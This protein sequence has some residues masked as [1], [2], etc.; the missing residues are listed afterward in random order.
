M[1]GWPL[2]V[3]VN[4]DQWR[5]GATKNVEDVLGDRGRVVTWRDVTDDH[6]LGEAVRSLLQ[7][8]KRLRSQ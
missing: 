3:V 1:T 8:N 2:L 7:A 5:P 4:T 6:V